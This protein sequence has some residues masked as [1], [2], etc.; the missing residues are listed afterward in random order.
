MKK[1]MVSRMFAPAVGLILAGV[2]LAAA[3]TPSYAIAP[4]AGFSCTD[5]FASSPFVMTNVPDVPAGTAP[6]V[7]IGAGW[8]LQLTVQ[9]GQSGS[10]IRTDTGVPIIALPGVSSG[11]VAGPAAGPPLV[12]TLD[13][14]DL[15]GGTA[16][17]P[18]IPPGNMNFSV[19]CIAPPPPPP[20]PPPPEPPLPPVEP[21][22]TPPVVSPLEPL[23]QYEPN[24]NL[25]IMEAMIGLHHDDFCLNYSVPSGED[26][27]GYFEPLQD[28]KF[29]GQYQRAVRAPN[30]QDLFA[31]GRV[32]FSDDP[33]IEGRDVN[34]DGDVDVISPPPLGCAVS[35][36]SLND[37]NAFATVPYFPTAE[38]APSLDA[39]SQFFSYDGNSLRGV[40]PLQSAAKGWA[41]DMIVDGAFI[42]RSFAALN[43]RTLTGTVVLSGRKLLDG[44]TSLGL[45]VRVGQALTKQAA[46]AGTLSSTSVGADIVLARQLTPTLFGALYG[47]AEIASN[48][49]V[50]GVVTGDYSSSIIKL[51][52]ELDGRMALDVFTLTPSVS[53]LL[54]YHYR[55]Q[56]TDSAGTA[57][58]ALSTLEVNGL[59]GFTIS[60]D[61]LLLEHDLVVSPFAGTNLR[62]DHLSTAPVVAQAMPVD[63]F[64]VGG[65]A[66][67]RFLWDRGASASIQVDASR[68]PTTTVLGAS[69][70]ISI[71]IPSN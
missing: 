62:I 63:P 23:V 57:L 69:G 19:Q 40:V 14:P 18:T 45:G 24:R 30:I 21:P 17:F 26:I 43:Q 47:G 10:I 11:T 59:A 50:V 5:A 22:V 37:V 42:D 38:M 67:I 34:A 61:F 36:E 16:L 35:A 51:G 39:I 20:P 32:T 60:R 48:H 8:Q 46:T 29:R 1:S 41:V 27:E 54:Q 31:P 12:I 15:G 71:P 7:T 28:N 65:S 58:A 70:T 68:G 3:T 25:D 49:A 33:V 2:A 6:G 53:I 56:F 64:R 66:G 4:V 55:P 9:R 52:G 44:R 13:A